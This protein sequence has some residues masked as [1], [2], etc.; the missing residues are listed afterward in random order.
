[1]SNEKHPHVPS[2]S[3]TLFYKSKRKEKTPQEE[4][5]SKRGN[6]RRITFYL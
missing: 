2:I 1:M 3:K 5:I 4:G 6:R